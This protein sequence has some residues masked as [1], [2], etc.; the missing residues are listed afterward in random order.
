MEGDIAGEPSE[1]EGKTVAEADEHAGRDQ[2]HSE[3]DEHAAYAHNPSIAADRA[4]RALPG[5]AG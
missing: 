4:T 1:A 2:D 5:G 3:D